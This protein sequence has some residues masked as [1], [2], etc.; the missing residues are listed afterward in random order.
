MKDRK[1]AYTCD[2]CACGLDSI[3]C[4]GCKE[5]EESARESEEI[6]RALEEEHERS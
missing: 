6:T 2:T 5:C 4:P 3:E 1:N